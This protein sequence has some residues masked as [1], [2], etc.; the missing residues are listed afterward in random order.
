V[1]T[2]DCKSVTSPTTG[3]SDMAAKTGNSY[4]TGTATDSFEISTASRVFLTMASPDKV[5]PSVSKWLWQCPST[6]NGIT[7]A[8]TGN[9]YIS[10]TT[11]DTMTIS[12][13]NVWFSATI[14]SKKLTW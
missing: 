14:S 12:T 3:N 10:W 7:A 11:T 9:T 1:P 5:S 13:A 6:G 8:E 4:T 2:S